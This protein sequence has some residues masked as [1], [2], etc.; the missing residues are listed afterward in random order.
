VTEKSCRSL[1]RVDLGGED[2]IVFG[3]T[4]DGMGPDV[5]ADPVIVDVDIGIVS[6]MAAAQK[7]FPVIIIFYL[8]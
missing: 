2:E 8:R 5:E 4:A 3:E 1:Q 7:R 6:S